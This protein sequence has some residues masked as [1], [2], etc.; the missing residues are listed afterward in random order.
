MFQ[1]C[2]L[3]HMESFQ[4]DTTF[5]KQTGSKIYRGKYNCDL[6][7]CEVVESKI[8]EGDDGWTLGDQKSKHKEIV[9]YFVAFF[10]KPLDSQPER[11][12]RDRK[13]R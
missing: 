12:G 9:M 4:R 2:E 5:F 13:G 8:M 10:L 1:P 11:Q 3:R 7:I 6:E